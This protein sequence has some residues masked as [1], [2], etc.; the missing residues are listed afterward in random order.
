MLDFNGLRAAASALAARAISAAP[1]AEGELT[2]LL[3][4]IH[5]HAADLE[6]AAAA[7]G[8]GPAIAGEVAQIAELTAEAF[9]SK[10]IAPFVGASAASSV[11]AEFVKAGE[12]AVAG[13]FAKAA[14]SA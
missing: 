9:I 1:A 12:T 6:Q 14:A 8:A 7:T 3:G 5:K 2:A 11:A 10:A 4:E 13:A